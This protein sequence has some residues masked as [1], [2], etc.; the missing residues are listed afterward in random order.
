MRI[1]IETLTDSHECDTCGCSYA[2]GGI[3]KIDG[4]VV[5]ERIPS[6]YCYDAPSFSESDLL[7]MALKSIGF[8]IEVDGHP[9]QICSHDDAY[10]GPMTP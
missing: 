9:Y 8:T 10:H 4:V 1:E 3:V 2:D 5:L 7:V 6:A